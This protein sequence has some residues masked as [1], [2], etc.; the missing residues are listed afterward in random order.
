MVQPPLPQGDPKEVLCGTDAW[1]K[2]TA[3]IYS[4]KAKLIW[5]DLEQQGNELEGKNK[6]FW[7]GIKRWHVGLWLQNTRMDIGDPEVLSV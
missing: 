2:V 7:P 3:N 5:F 6:N 4:P 1:Y